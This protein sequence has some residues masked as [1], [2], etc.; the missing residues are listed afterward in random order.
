MAPGQFHDIGNRPQHGHVT[1]RKK[2]NGF[3]GTASSPRSTN[4]MDVTVATREQQTV[5]W[6]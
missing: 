5:E 1:F 3:T 2:S 4:A 6:H